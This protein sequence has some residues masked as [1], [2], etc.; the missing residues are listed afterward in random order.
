MAT[1]TID[2]IKDGTNHFFRQDNLAARPRL[3]D[4]FDLGQVRKVGG[5]LDFDLLI[6]IQDN[7]VV[8]R[9]ISND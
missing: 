5:G 1:L 9:R 7:L 3:T 2:K 6:V 4:F 8:R